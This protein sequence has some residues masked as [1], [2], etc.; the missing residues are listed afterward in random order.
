MCVALCSSLSLAVGL[1]LG[2]CSHSPVCCSCFS[3]SSNSSSFVV[4]HRI[5]SFFQTVQ[6]LLCTTFIN[7][8]AALRPWSYKFVCDIRATHC[9]SQLKNWTGFIKTHPHV[10]GVHPVVYI[11]LDDCAVSIVSNVWILFIQLPACTTFLIEI[12]GFTTFALLNVMQL[13]TPSRL[14]FCAALVKG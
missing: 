1:F 12:K 3:F 2:A 7:L 10:H 6:L 13:C 8:T 9:P 11:Q 5:F 4:C 14:K